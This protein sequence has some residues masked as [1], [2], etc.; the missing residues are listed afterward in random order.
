MQMNM[1]TFTARHSCGGKTVK[2]GDCLFT[3]N[4]VALLTYLCH[5]C[6]PQEPCP[7]NRILRDRQGK[8]NA[9]NLRRAKDFAVSTFAFYSPPQAPEGCP[10]RAEIRHFTRTRQVRVRAPPC[11]TSDDGVCEARSASVHQMRDVVI[12]FTPTTRAH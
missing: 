6:F 7:T 8:A 2:S 11:L 3:A 5:G 1:F 9:A 4:C 10:A 12:Y